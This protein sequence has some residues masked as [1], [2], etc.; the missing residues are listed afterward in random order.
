MYISVLSL[1]ISG[2]IEDSHTGQTCLRLEDG[3]GLLSDKV[4]S[5]NSN[6]FEVRYYDLSMVL[7]LGGCCITQL[8]TSVADHTFPNRNRHSIKHLRDLFVTLLA[9]L[10]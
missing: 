10:L 2:D 1:D 3:R 9:Y 4:R 5:Y 6:N 8:P 7:C